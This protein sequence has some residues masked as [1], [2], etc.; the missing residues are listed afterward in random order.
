MSGRHC[1]SPQAGR[2]NKREHDTM[3]KQ[4]RGYKPSNSSR[5]AERIEK[6]ACRQAGEWI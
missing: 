5:V 3:F 6:P 1:P 2:I 4:L